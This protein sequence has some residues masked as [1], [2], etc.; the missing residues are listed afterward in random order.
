MRLSVLA[1]GLLLS[2]GVTGVDAQ[3]RATGNKDLVLT[4]RNAGNFSVFL[5]V[6]EG[7][8]WTQQLRGTSQ[9]TVFA[10]T[11]DAFG[12]VSG[13]LRDSLIRDK[14]ALETLI[15]NH[16]VEGRVSSDDA[17]SG[18]RGMSFLGGTALRVDTSG[19]YVRVN[20]AQ[21]IKPDMMASNGIIHVVDQVW[22]P[23]LSVRVRGT[24][25]TDSAERVRQPRN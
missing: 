8:G 16:V 6:I 10:P 18:T 23:S 4:L 3:Q 9:F 25:P 11:D 1:I 12:R 20:G 2:L 17:K 24:N 21:V 14:A 22:L 5:Q 7:A 13:A 15:R 19:M